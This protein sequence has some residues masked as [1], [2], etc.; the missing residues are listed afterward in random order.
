VRPNTFTQ[1]LHENHSTPRTERRRVQAYINEVG[2][3]YDRAQITRPADGSKPQPTISVTR[4]LECRLCP[5][6]HPSR[7]FKTSNW[8]VMKNHGIEVH[9]T[10]RAGKRTLC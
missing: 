1:H 5:R 10:Q 8:K 7:P 3:T 2:W 4:G 9:K 6:E